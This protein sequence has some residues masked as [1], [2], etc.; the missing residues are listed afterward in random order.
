MKKYLIGFFTGIGIVALLIS[1]CGGK[2]LWAFIL[3][4]ILGTLI[5][6]LS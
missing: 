4:H 2:P 5:G 6:G 1:L 3:F